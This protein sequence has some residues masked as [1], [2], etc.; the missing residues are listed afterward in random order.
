MVTAAVSL[1]EN[2]VQLFFG[3]ILSDDLASEEELQRRR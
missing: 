3:G 2:L 1:P